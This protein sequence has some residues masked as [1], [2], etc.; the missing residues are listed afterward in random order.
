M[1]KTLL[2]SVTVAL[3]A[4]TTLAGCSS[5]GTVAGNATAPSSSTAPASASDA[6]ETL[7]TLPI[8]GRAPKTGYDRVG[9]FGEAWADV[10]HNGCDTRDDILTRDLTNV[11]KR[12]TCEVLT[13][14]LNDPYTGK[15]IAFVR[16]VHTSMAI[17]ID[18]RVPLSNAWQT[19]AQQ[20]TQDQSVALANDPLNLIAVDGPTNGQKSDGDAATWL[21]PVK[22]YR[23]AY[24]TAQIQVKAK[25][26]LWVTQAEHD[27]MVRWIATCS[28][29]PAATPSDSQTPAQIPA[30][31]TTPTSTASDTPAPAAAAPSAGA[32]IH[33][34]SYCDNAGATA[35]AANGKT[36]VC[37]KTGPD[38]GGRLHW[39]A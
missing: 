33:P 3:L 34:G 27:A 8:K 28:G 24:V 32:P 26:G 30:P 6:L 21:P 9:K 29:Y 4:L 35:V 2:A 37:G 10:D 13:G 5:V 19:G 23:C 17:Q 1:K 38:A 16:G 15:S 36:Y 39:N 12:G 7:A 20:L 25:Y 31:D 14:T 18:H 11:T 22:S